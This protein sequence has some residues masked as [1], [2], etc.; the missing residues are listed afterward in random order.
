MSQKPLNQREQGRPISNLRVLVNE[1]KN[2]CSPNSQGFPET[3]TVFTLNAWLMWTI[4]FLLNFEN[5]SL[6]KCVQKGVQNCFPAP[7]HWYVGRRIRAVYQLCWCHLYVVTLDTC[8]S[9][10][11]DM[12]ASLLF[13]YFSGPGL[14]HQIPE[15]KSSLCK[16]TTLLTARQLTLWGTVLNTQM[17][18]YYCK[19]P[20][21][22]SPRLQ[23][24]P[25]KMWVGFWPANRE[26]NGV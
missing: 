6:I 1:A 7:H 17:F 26:S 10:F 21:D 16:A 15:D 2:R 22:N 5:Y 3:Y 19:P 8:K 12:C 14:F 25:T 13:R 20:S 9:H 18:S 24:H 23:V 11:L 4:C